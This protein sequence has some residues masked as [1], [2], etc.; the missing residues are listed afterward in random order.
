[1][2]VDHIAEVFVPQDCLLYFIMRLFGRMTA[3]IMAFFIAEGFQHT[4]NRKKYLMRLAVFGVISQPVFIWMQS[5][6]N[7]VNLL[8]ILGHWNVMMS[9]AIALICLIVLESNLPETPRLI[10]LAVCISLG[11]FTDW[12]LMIPVWTVIFYLF[13]NDLKK[14]MLLFAASCTLLLTLLFA[15]NYEN[16]TAFTFQYGT[17]LAIIPLSLY[18]GKRG[19]AKHKNLS[20]WFF[21]IYYPVHMLIICVLSHTV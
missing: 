8:M 13:R 1:M 14:K 15:R 3:P 5:C 17:L 16:F 19:S 18:N 21:Y 10:L 12:S 7:P 9:L 11:H 4:H 2:T 6:T 20:R